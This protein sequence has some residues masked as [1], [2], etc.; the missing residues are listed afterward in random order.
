MGFSA[1]GAV[2]MG[3]TF[4]YSK[5]NRPNFIVPVY[6]WMNVVGPYR[7]P[8]DAPPMLA[9]CAS[10]DPLDLASKSINLY[11]NWLKAEKSAGL[12]M[13]SKGGHGFGM[14]KQGLPSDHWIARFHDW[15]MAEG[16]IVPEGG[17]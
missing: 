3:V 2:A 7:V 13:Y 16:L 6:A 4:N 15:A 9:I 12:H 8:D 11:S 1:G 5:E 17:N 10:D 14:K